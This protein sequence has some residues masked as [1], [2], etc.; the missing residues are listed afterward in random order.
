MIVAEVGFNH[1]GDVALCRR[2]IES[3]AENGADLV[4]L[5][6]FVAE[7]LYS[8]KFIAN[9]PADPE[10]KIPLYEFFK[11]AE[12]KS[13]EYEELFIFARDLDIP[14]FS[15][16]FDEGSL[17]MLVDMGVPAVKIA[18]P[19][20]THLNL[21]KKA[22]QTNLPIVLSTG[23]GDYDEIETAVN[24]I[25]GEGNDRIV[26]LHCV[27]NYPSRYEE[28]NL[29]CLSELETRF[30]IPVGLSDHTT[31]NLSAIVAASLGAVMIEKHFTLDRNLPGADHA[32]SMEPD[33]LRQLKHA[34]VQ[35]GKILGDGIRKLQPS[36]N[37]V[38][39]TARRSLVAR[40]DIEPETLLTADMFCA[41]RPGTGI[42][43]NGLDRIVGKKAKVK[44]SAEQLIDWE[45]ISS[46]A[47]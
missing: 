45:M 24:M 36:E 42:P 1:N 7:D 6:T 17:E 26:L 19:D 40:I 28:M 20:L 21:I 34:T 29:R 13:S 44:I 5:Q 10:K 3:A 32:M 27:S 22:A 16:P 43:P 15:T 4:K 12:L 35:V 33:E 39:Q 37:P 38:K 25:R 30:K 41:K 46:D 14:L 18:S 47:N 11:R 9:D 2:M 8:K 31:D 23:M